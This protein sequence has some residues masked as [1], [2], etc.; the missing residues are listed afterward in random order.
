MT[1]RKA[2]ERIRIL[3]YGDTNSLINQIGKK[4]FDDLLRYGLI[5]QGK[6][7]PDVW[8]ITEKGKIRSSALLSKVAK[9]IAIL[10]LK[11]NRWK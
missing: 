3:K 7:F 4:N 6:Q 1:R 9:I 11:F 8:R 5:R 10:L 2:I